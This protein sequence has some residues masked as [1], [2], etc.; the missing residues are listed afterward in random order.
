[1]LNNLE[2]YE[3]S[4]L[5]D[6]EYGKYQGDFHLFLN[7]IPKGNILDLACGTG[8][9]AISLAQK[10]F[11]VVALDAS[12]P[13]LA[14]A[15]QK[16][17]GLSIEWIHGDI[18]DFHLHKRFDL[19]LMAGNAFQALL[20][21]E[22]QRRMLECVREHLK[23]S[24]LFVFNTRNLQGND[25]KDVNEFEFWHCFQDHH[26]ETVGVYG[27]QEVEVSQNLVTHITKRI[28]ES[29]ETTSTI[30]LRFTPYPQL[31]KLLTQAGFEVCEVYGDDQKSPFHKG[32]ASIIPVC[33]LKKGVL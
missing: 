15:R 25:F 6:A 14:L 26:G 10:G 22:D 7:L 19:I 3:N 29:K 21:E 23:P 20:T 27:K 28:W 30:R 9:L 16:A 8:R 18:R 32:S 33:K 11:K 17:R 1:M 5:Y 13:M 31:M 2:E 4:S 12:C 24:G